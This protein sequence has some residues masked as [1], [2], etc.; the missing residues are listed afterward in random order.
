MQNVHKIFL[1]TLFWDMVS[2]TSVV[3]DIN[4]SVKP[5]ILYTLKM[6]LQVPLKT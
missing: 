1:I 4:I 5:D 2:C 3:E 6:R